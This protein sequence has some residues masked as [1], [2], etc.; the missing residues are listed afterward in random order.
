MKHKVNILYICNEYPPSPHGGIGSYTRFLAEA[1][2]QRGHNVQVVGFDPTI[3]ASLTETINGVTVTRHPLPRRKHGRISRL[4]SFFLDRKQLSKHVDEICASFKPD[5]IESYDWNAP[6]SKRPVSGHLVVRMHGAHTVYNR[7]MGIGWNHAMLLAYMERKNI[8]FADSLA[9]VSRLIADKTVTT[10]GTFS[11]EIKVIYNGVNALRFSSSENHQRDP[12]RL[13]FVGRVH[14][15]KGI[16][17]L[18]DALGTV[19]KK[20]QSVFLDVAGPTD[21]DYAQRIIAGVPEAM[22]HRIHFLGRV[23][24]TKLPEIYASA[25]VCLLPSRVEAFPIVPL[26]AMACGTPVIMSSLVAANEIIAH[27]VDGY[28][29]DPTDTEAFANCILDALA[30]QQQIESMRRACRK[31]IMTQ[32]SLEKIVAD[33]ERF[34]RECLQ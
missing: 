25:N 2:A 14:H 18:I 16:D 15:H 20:N 26:E 11:K 17:L 5:I 30:N 22:R 21:S 3:N 24:N 7:W 1:L 12:L 4:V 32:F 23:D 31:K 6:I 10:F 19:F 8:S 27:G 13:L 34:Y 9:A 29:A 33:N 28:I